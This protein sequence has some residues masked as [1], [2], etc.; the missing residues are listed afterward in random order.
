M[1]RRRLNVCATCGFAF[2][3]SGC[4][5]HRAKST[6]APGAASKFLTRAGRQA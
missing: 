1:N 3:E 2:H 4:I 5:H 6:R